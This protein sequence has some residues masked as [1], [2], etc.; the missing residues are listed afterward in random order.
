MRGEL[1]EEVGGVCDEEVKR[2]EAWRAVVRSVRVRVNS[3]SGG[4]YGILGGDRGGVVGCHFTY[5]CCSW[6]HG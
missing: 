6:W 5:E 2:A 3:G 1:G 4:G